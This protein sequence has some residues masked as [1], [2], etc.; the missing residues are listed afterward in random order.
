[1]PLPVRALG[2]DTDPLWL[3]EVYENVLWTGD[4]A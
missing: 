1:M 4:F 2:L 3:A